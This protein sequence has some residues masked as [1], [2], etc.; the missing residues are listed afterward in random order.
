MEE[1]P[2]LYYDPTSEPCRA[3]YWWALNAKIPLK[4]KLTWLG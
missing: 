2:I 3:V 4:V 1:T